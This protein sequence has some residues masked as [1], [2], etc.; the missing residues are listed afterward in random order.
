MKTPNV[1]IAHSWI[2]LMGGAEQVLKSVCEIIPQKEIYSLVVDLEFIKRFLGDVSVKT[3][4]LNK[5]PFVKDLYRNFLP[6]RK[7]VV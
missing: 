7:S 5:V 2:V 3:S 6:D 1:A 4:S